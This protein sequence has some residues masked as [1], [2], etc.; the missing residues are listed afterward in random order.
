MADSFQSGTVT[1]LH[2]MV[3]RPLSELE[4]ELQD[5]ATELLL[6]LIL[7]SL[8]SELEQQ[9]LEN[10]IQELQ[11]VN[12]LKQITVGLDQADEHQFREALR[13][14]GRLPQSVSVLWNDGPRLRAVDKQLQALKL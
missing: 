5:F 9:A 14:F 10:I 1:T 2:N 6:G 7:P 4:A 11:K 12:Y 13:Y 8:F 3:N